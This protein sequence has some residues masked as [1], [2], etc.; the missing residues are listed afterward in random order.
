M[1]AK[2]LVVEDD[3]DIRRNMQKLLESEGYAVELAENGQVALDSLQTATELPAVIIL[4]L[5][6]PVMDGFQ[7]R[8]RQERDVRLAAIPV[9]I[10]TADGH[11]DEKK[12]QAGAL[13]GLRK[14]ADVDEILAVIG[15][16]CRPG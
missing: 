3:K 4:D 2:I 13:A 11:I 6:M 10:M 12:A 5:M 7:F 15:Q 16:I 1:S 8:D 9:V 14:P